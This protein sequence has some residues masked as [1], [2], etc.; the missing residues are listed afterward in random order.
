[1]K[2]L[3]EDAV[4]VCDHET[5]IVAIA[6][7]QNLV[8][9]NGRAVLVGNDPEGR[10]ISGC[11]NTGAMIK[12]CTSTL[13]VKN[14]YSDFVHIEGRAV[15][16]DTVTGLTDGTPPGVVDYKVRRPGQDWVEQR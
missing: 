9:I 7:S 8:T 5:G 6:A 13:K 15:C 11:P 14:G 4:L 12:P 16:L 1:M 3:T 2:I 10:P